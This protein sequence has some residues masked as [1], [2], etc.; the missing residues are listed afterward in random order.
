[1]DRF[2]PTF[3]RRNP[4]PNRYDHNIEKSIKEAKIFQRV[5][6]PFGSPQKGPFCTSLVKKGDVV[7]K[8]QK[9][10]DSEIAAA[11]PVHSSVD[12]KIVSIG[13]HHHP[14]GGKISSVEI[15]VSEEEKGEIRAENH[16]PPIPA[17]DREAFI[18]KLRVYGLLFH[19]TLKAA[20]NKKINTILINA[21]SF[22]PFISSGRQILS[23]YPGPIVWAILLL[24]EAVS[25]K[26]AFICLEKNE[27]GIYQKIQTLFSQ[28]PLNT[29]SGSAIRV[30]LLKRPVPSFAHYFLANLADLKVYKNRVLF[31]IQ[32]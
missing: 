27:R 5:I 16:L 7:Q 17:F 14:L 3:A 31:I 2:W 15:E 26:R 23:E 29:K 12:G 10:G 25:G 4:I 6:I 24:L 22:D 20:Q 13:P 1:M 19:N 30:H 28:S 32:W 18:Q 8:G 11:T 9:I 21:T